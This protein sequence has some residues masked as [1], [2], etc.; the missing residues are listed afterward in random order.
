MIILYYGDLVMFVLF[1]FCSCCISHVCCLFWWLFVACLL[2]IL[3][4][5][6]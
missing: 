6:W 1:V 4:I 2:W 5:L 3:V